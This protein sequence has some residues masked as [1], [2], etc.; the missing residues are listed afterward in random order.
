MNPFDGIT[1]DFTVFGVEFT[2]WWQLLLGGAWAIGFIIAAF[3]AI[4]AIVTYMSAKN[5]N[6]SGDVADAVKGMK[7]WGLGVLLLASV[8]LIFTIITL[9]AG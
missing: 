6:R 5:D 7:R 2:N 1:P 3:Q 9:I 8:P 4:L